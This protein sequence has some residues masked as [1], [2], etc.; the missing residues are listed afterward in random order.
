[1]TKVKITGVA[2]AALFVVGLFFRKPVKDD[3]FFQPP[4]SYT[5]H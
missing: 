3:S 5:F 1:M 2:A 4:V